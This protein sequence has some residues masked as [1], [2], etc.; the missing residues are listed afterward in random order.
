MTTTTM[1]PTTTTTP[2]PAG[3]SFLQSLA[4]ATLTIVGSTL[5]LAL[6]WH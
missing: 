4:L 2:P 1:T 6:L 3:L 5:G